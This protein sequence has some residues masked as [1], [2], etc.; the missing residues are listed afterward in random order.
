MIRAIRPV[1]AALPFLLPALAPAAVPSTVPVQGVLS[2]PA[3]TPLD[4]TFTV[5]FALY[6]VATGGT[7]FHIE[8]QSIVADRGAFSAFLSPELS[9]F[10]A[11]EAWLGIQVAT[12]SEMAPRLKIGTVPYA[13]HAA[14]TDAVPAGAVM[15]FDLD[16]C[17]PG[18]SALAEAQGRLLAGAPAGGT[19]GLAVGTALADGENRAHAHA[20]D[21]AASSTSTVA[22]H[23]HA[24]APPNSYSTSVYHRHAWA[25]F[26]Q[27]TNAWNSY[28]STG[29]TLSLGDWGDGM[30]S[31]GAGNYPLG[32]NSG[33][34]STAAYT[35]PPYES[36]A[37]VH[38]NPS[39]TTAAAGGH[40]HAVDVP[41]TTSTV[42]N[43]LV[44]YLQLLAC[45]KD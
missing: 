27:A 44:P 37:H 43:G 1:L 28:T 29:T 13:A 32:A 14:S 16:A 45:R 7:P 21:P 8:T 38:S 2:S 41:Y 31:A 24:A 19:V 36:T 5:T 40:S 18:W 12:D 20:V 6:D 42:V 30:D 39:F 11:T 35:L 26:N 23:A 15:F 10:R 25:Y 22:T 33:T 9:V 3:G 4:G 34:L 17:P